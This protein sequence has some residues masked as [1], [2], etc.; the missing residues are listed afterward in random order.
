MVRRPITPCGCSTAIEIATGNPGPHR[1]HLPGCQH[2]KVGRKDQGRS[3]G[4]SKRRRLI[5]R[6]DSRC[7]YCGQRCS[8]EVPMDNA[9]FLTIDHII[10]VSRGGHRTSDVNMV[11]ACVLCNSLKADRMPWEIDMWPLNGLGGCWA[12]RQD[13]A[14]SATVRG[15]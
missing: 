7:Q 9:S 13:V 4:R 6:D 14:G 5:H 15:A 8:W 1:A 11:V 10:P 3:P 12:P 2:Y